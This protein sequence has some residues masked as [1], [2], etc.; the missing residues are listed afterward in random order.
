MLMMIVMMYD[1]DNDCDDEDVHD[2]DDVD[3]DDDRCSS[4]HTV[5]PIELILTIQMELICRQSK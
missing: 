4:V 2:N 5:F 1:H 3:H